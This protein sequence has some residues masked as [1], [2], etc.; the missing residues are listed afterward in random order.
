MEQKK[1]EFNYKENPVVLFRQSE[2]KGS[3]VVIHNKREG[4]IFT[5]MKKKVQ[6]KKSPS[7]LNFKEYLLK[8]IV[9]NQIWTDEDLETLF[10][11]TKEK[12]LDHD[13]NLIDEAIV[14][15]KSVVL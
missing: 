11:S 1:N 9:D 7:K 10:E 4:D 6:S 12:F 15:V 5:I 2:T 13:Q 8:E 3:K 14:Y